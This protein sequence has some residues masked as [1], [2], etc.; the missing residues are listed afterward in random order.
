MP[1]SLTQQQAQALAN[2]G[3]AAMR[4][5]QPQ[6]ARDALAQ[7]VAAGLVSVDLHLALA[8]AHLALGDATQAMQSVDAALLLD[9]RDIAA[10]VFKGDRMDAARIQIVELDSGRHV[11]FADENREAQRAGDRL[12][13][14]PGHEFYP[15]HIP[16]V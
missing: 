8:H 14:L 5:G 4:A 6:L 16:K 3:M 2:Q 9:P 13:L 7:L 1:S 12:R 11:L 10:L 15:G